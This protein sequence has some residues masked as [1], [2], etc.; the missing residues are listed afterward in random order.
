M[1]RTA[2]P[3]S[4]AESRGSQIRCGEEVSRRAILE[5][6]SE[7]PVLTLV[8]APAGYGKT[9]LLRQWSRR[10]ASHSA[11]VNLSLDEQAVRPNALAREL[12]RI[13]TGTASDEPLLSEVI[14]GLPAKTVILMDDGDSIAHSEVLRDLVALIEKR[15]DL[16]LAIASRGELGLPLAKRRLCRSI[17]EIGVADLRF[18]RAEVTE[19]LTSR[20]PEL[21][22]AGELDAL[23]TKLHGWP[24]GYQLATDSAVDGRTS[25]I[26]GDW[27]RVREYFDEEVI[28]NV[29]GDAGRLLAEC[30]VFDVVPLDALEQTGMNCEATRGVGDFLRR[31]IDLHFDDRRGLTL[32]FHPLLRDYLRTR[33]P[34]DQASALRAAAIAYYDAQGDY[35]SA[36]SIALE[37]GDDERAAMMLSAHYRASDAKTDIGIMGLARQIK[38]EQRDRFPYIL[39]GMAGSLIMGFHLEESNS[40]LIKA[41]RL[42]E[43]KTSPLP[44]EDWEELNAILLQREMILAHYEDR[45][46]QAEQLSIALLDRLDFV[47][48]K[49]RLMTYTILMIV[50]SERFRFK[51]TERFYALGLR[52]ARS[53]G[54]PVDLVPIDTFYARYLFLV[55]RGSEAARRFEDLIALAE[56][57]YGPSPIVATAAAIALA[58]VCVDRG[59]EEQ[60]DRLVTE[61]VERSRG[62]GFASIMI[63]SELSFARLLRWKGQTE[64]GLAALQEP[65][66]LSGE[67][68]DRVKIAMTVERIVWLA[69]LRRNKEVTSVAASIG[70]SL[71]NPPA[72]GPAVSASQESFAYAWVHLARCRLQLDAALRVARRWLRFC[73]G[74]QAGRSIVKWNVAI[75]ALSLLNG[76]G[77]AAGR[78][79]RRAVAAAAVGG[80]QRYFLEEGRLLLDPLSQIAGADLDVHEADLVAALLSKLGSAPADLVEEESDE[81]VFAALTTAEVRILKLVD[82]GLRNR[83]IGD[84]LGMTEGTVKWYMQNVFT[85][86]G[87]R[88]RSL[89]A[90]RARSFSILD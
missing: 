36:C 89:A 26:A 80:Y 60:A 88:R 81:A 12:E 69:Q 49:L 47:R 62:F 84:A 10:L 41:R 22:S 9:T 42:I 82:R 8:R 70:M 78:Y 34:N 5:K 72:P 48:P 15:S 3:S 44:C 37:L 51:D 32:R 46:D 54:Q 11:V 40:L 56:R 19:F 68:Y 14:E 57:Q 39:L 31:G 25:L 76:D 6:L 16:H 63:A 55:G 13:A 77:R 2:P 21:P 73:D 74:V 67:L 17:L 35:R 30:S 66:A 90:S 4:G 75:C 45:D 86:L 65:P 71:S 59:D 28:A 58:D 24:C 87:T 27:T 61:Y 79:L 20:L 7:L 52:D 23:E 83:E 50:S 29:S 33:L 38:P 43:E 85:K 18:T 53:T 64:R 1:I